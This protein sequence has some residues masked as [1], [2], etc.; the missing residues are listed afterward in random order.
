MFLRTHRILFSFNRCGINRNRHSPSRYRQGA[1]LAIIFLLTIVAPGFAQN[2][3]MLTL[4][5]AEAMAIQNHPQIQAAQNEVNYAAQ[6]I[7]ESRA[8]FYPNVSGDLTGSQGNNGA[9][10]GAGDLPASRLFDRFGQGVIV[11]QLITDS[12]RTPNLVASARLESQATAQN[13]QATQY[14]VLLGVNRAYFGVLHAQA[15]VKVAQQTVSARQLL[16]DQVTELARNNLKSQLDVSFADVNVSQAK[17]LLL[18]AQ[19][20]VQQA[21]AELGRSM[22][23]AQPANYTLSDEPLPQGPPATPDQL[24]AEALASRP[25]LAGLQYARDAAYK[26]AEAEKDL[27]RPVVSAV[28]VGG[29]LPLIKNTAGSSIP[30]EYEGI[31]ANVSIPVFNGHLFSARREA[32]DQRALEADQRL[33]DEQQ[34]I[35]QDVR[36]A[37]ASAND[38]FQRID[39]TAQFLRQASLALDLAQGRYNLGLSSIVELTQA[40]LN[41]TQAEIENLNAKYDYQAQYA[42]LQY[43]AGL[44]R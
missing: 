12:G 31:G 34:Q 44:L 1:V 22:G 37:W 23:S 41:L 19:D 9:R 14:N 35:S 18:R 7:I 20:A 17:L 27:S 15:V 6:Q 21:M 11:R 28:A 8:A 38:A 30:A 26:F 13:A 32:A 4:Q 36:I 24:V 3:P 2:P 29:F 16:S 39:V 43:A 5:Q 10:I 42:A 40:Q 33:R 25:E